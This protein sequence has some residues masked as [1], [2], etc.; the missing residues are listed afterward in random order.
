LV[1][2]FSLDD[3]DAFVL[4]FAEEVTLGSSE[5]TV[6]CIAVPREYHPFHDMDNGNGHS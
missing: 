1:F 6:T 5:R 2:G 3:A 4:T